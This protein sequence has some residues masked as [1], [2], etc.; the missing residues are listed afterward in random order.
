MEIILVQFRLLHV[1][2]SRRIE[3]NQAEAETEG[4]PAHRL[5]TSGED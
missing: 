1:L 5:M 4:P 3:D 2:F